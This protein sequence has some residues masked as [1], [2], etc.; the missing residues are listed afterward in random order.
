MAAE[1][2]SFDGPS[3][4]MPLLR[5]V[6]APDGDASVYRHSHVRCLHD[7]HDSCAVKRHQH[8]RQEGQTCRHVR[9]KLHVHAKLRGQRRGEPPPTKAVV[10]WPSPLRPSPTSSPSPVRVLEVWEETRAVLQSAETGDQVQGNSQRLSQNTWVV[11]P[12]A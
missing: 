1:A 4:Y 2:F 6:E 7:T 8:R 9:V 11:F 3:L 12:S 10:T 5:K